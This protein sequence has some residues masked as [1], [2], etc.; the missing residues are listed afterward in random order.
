MEIGDLVMAI[1]K[2]VKVE[3]NIRYRDDE[4]TDYHSVAINTLKLTIPLPGGV[5]IYELDITDNLKAN[6]E[7]ASQL[8]E[9]T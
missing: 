9:K 3:T 2:N 6:I 4:G 8:S 1:I 5:A 7:F